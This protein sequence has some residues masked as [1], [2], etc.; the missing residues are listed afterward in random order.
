MGN[1]AVKGS[2]DQ[3]T[4]LPSSVLMEIGYLQLGSLAL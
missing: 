3:S 4:S 1:T 2:E